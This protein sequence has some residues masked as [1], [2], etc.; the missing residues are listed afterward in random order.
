MYRYLEK[1]TGTYRVLGYLDLVTNDFP[2]DEN[3]SIDDSYEDLYI[4]CSRSK[5]VIKH[6]YDQDKLVAC[7]YGKVS[8]ARN[9]FNEIKGKYKNIDVELEE[10]GEDGLIYFYDED[11]KKVATILKPR[12]SGASIKWNSNK[13]LPK[14][15]YNIPKEDLKKYNDIIKDLDRTQ[16]MLFGKKLISK[17]LN[18]DKLKEQQKTS[19]LSA[20]EYI[21]SSGL[22]DKYIKAAKEEIKNYG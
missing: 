18:T 11:I 8:A 21:H 14:I 10:V 13:N 19:R 12:T 4:P 6:T 20:K 3:G 17:V 5:C 15:E 7:F 16:K 22:W 1:Y 9:A 2:R